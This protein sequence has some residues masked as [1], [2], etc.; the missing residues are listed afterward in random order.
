MT[1]V[2][3]DIAELVESGQNAKQIAT[4]LASDP[5]HVR[6]VMAVD[7]DPEKL[8]LYDVLEHH[9]LLDGKLESEVLATENET[10]IKAW[11]KLSRHMQTVNRVVRCGTVPEV[12]FFASTLTQLAAKAHPEF[13]GEIA[14]AMNELTG[15]VRFAGVTEAV[16]QELI[17]EHEKLE[18]ERV[19]ADRI[20]NAA[21]LASERMSPGD[22]LE[23]VWVQAWSDAGA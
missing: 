14:A 18:A 12:G 8:D 16:V 2:Y 6:D 10:I 19:I 21:A 7:F 1:V 17:D 15:G 11:Q 3:E 5:R 4:L 23:A 20:T 13:A 9:D 22:D